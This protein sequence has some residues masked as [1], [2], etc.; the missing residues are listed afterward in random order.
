[1]GRAISKAEMTDVSQRS[2]EL[3][4]VPAFLCH[5]CGCCCGIL[6]GINKHGDP[7]TIVSSTLLPHVALDEC[8][9]CHKCARACHVAAIS[10]V[11]EPK[12]AGG[13]RMFMP[14]FRK[15][16]VML[17]LSAGRQPRTTESRLKNTGAFVRTYAAVNVRI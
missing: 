9:G 1:M 17:A 16:I 13:K 7:N 6:D 11:P 10:L 2:K 4:L 3:K 14:C 5:C 15:F 12:K 8:N